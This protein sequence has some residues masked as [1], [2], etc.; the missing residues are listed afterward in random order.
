M[1]YHLPNMLLLMLIKYTFKNQESLF[2]GHYYFF[3]SKVCNTKWQVLVDYYK[4]I[5]QKNS[6]SFC[7]YV[8]LDEQCLHFVDFNIVPKGCEW[9]LISV[10]YYPSNMVLLMLIKYTFGN[11]EGTL[12]G[13]TIFFKFK[14]YN[15]K[16]IILVD[17]YMKIQE[18][19][20]G[21]LDSMNDACIL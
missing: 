4:K 9:G 12:L 20:I 11:Q 21:M 19:L 13:I 17:Y 2:V 15:M 3:K 18:V 14:V 16:W 1:V 10:F 5:L 6:R 8:W 7:W